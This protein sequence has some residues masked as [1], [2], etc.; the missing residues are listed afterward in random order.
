MQQKFKER[1]KI[2][3]DNNDLFTYWKFLPDS[4]KP[5]YAIKIVILGTESTGKT[6]LTEKLAQHYKCTC[7]NEAGRDIVSV[8]NSFLFEDLFL[9]AAEHARRIENAVLGESPLII[10]DTDIHITKSYSTFTFDRELKVEN[11]IYNSNKAN[12]YLYLNND[13]EFVQDGTRFNE[14]NR[15]LLDLSHRQTLKQ[16]NINFVEI[17]GTWEQRFE[18]AVEQIDKI[19]S[20]RKNALKFN[21][22]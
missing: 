22:S 10:I 21:T 13:V 5:D 20:S 12:L 18:K 3:A 14:Y 9:I 19:I 16:H 2:M 11:N 7:V 17:K 15:N 4:V 8:S 1:I 6:T